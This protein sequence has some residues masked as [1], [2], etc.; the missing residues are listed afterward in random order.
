MTDKQKTQF[1]AMHAALVSLS[2]D[3]QTPNQLR[4]SAKNSYGLDYEEALEWPMR[5]CRRRP[6]QRFRVLKSWL[7]FSLMD[8][9]P[10]P[11]P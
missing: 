9:T 6:K 2:K 10:N 4:K 5:T 1:N 11:E 7:N 8:N 3:Y